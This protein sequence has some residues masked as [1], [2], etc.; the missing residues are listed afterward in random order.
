MRKLLVWLLLITFSFSVLSPAL[1]AKKA[2]KKIKKKIVKVQKKKKAKAKKKVVKYRG[3]RPKFPIYKEKE[4]L[5][6]PPPPPQVIEPE[7]GK[8][9]YAAKPQSALF[10]EGGIGGGALLFSLGYRRAVLDKIDLEAGVGY[11]LGSG[12]GV[13]VLDV[14]RAVYTLPDY[15]AG[16]G[17]NYV[18]YSATVGSLLGVGKIPS[19]S[20]LGLEIFGGKRLG[21]LFGNGNISVRAG[22]S[23]ALGLRLSG[24]L[25]F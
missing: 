10:S 6:P 22:Y 11:G 1:A 14:A 12:Y 7:T 24:A 25:E 13:L 2:K 16:A 15:F 23:T 9:V 8:P 17:I 5:P 4:E 19:L 21:N 18:S 3:P 20:V